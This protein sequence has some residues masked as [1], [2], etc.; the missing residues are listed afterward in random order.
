MTA[1]DQDAEA[2][3]KM[4]KPVVPEIPRDLENVDPEKTIA[5]ED[6]ESTAIR[7]V[8]PHVKAVDKDLERDAARYG[9]ETESL[10]RLSKEVRRE[11]E[12]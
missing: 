1:R 8:S 12:V 7:R 10:R 6:W 4:P 9:W 5:R 3:M 2:T 11:E